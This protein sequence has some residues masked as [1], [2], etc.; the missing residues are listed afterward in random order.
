MNYEDFQCDWWEQAQFSALCEHWMWFSSPFGW[1]FPILSSY[2]THMCWSLLCWI[3]QHNSLKI[4]EHSFCT[5]LI[6]WYSAL[7]T[8]IDLTSLDPLCPQSGSSSAQ[9]LGSARLYLGSISLCCGLV[10]FS[11][12]S[13]LGQL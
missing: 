3:F 7:W 9:L 2:F 12:C 13:K 8:L 10:S 6:F 4:P 11:R 5:A 1:L